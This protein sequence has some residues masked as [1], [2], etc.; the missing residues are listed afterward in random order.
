[1]GDNCQEC[2]EKNELFSKFD[3]IAS[4]SRSKQSSQAENWAMSLIQVTRHRVGNGN[5]ISGRVHLGIVGYK[6]HGKD[7][8]Q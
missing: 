6:G 3:V 8:P 2:D 4:R 7:S 5:C 1:M